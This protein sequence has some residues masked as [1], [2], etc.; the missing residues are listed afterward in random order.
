MKQV[1]PAYRQAEGVDR[2]NTDK[3]AA[4]FSA[5][6]KTLGETLQTREANEITHIY[7]AFQV[8]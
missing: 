2:S 4:T 5:K 6:H 7:F 8:K 3:H 1:T